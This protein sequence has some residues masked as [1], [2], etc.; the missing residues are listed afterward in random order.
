M[1]LPKGLAMAALMLLM[2]MTFFDILLRSTVNA[3]I[4]ATT[5]L[6][7]ILLMFVVFAAMPEV[8]LRGT[9]VAVDLLAP[10]LDRVGFARI[11]GLI[12]IGSAVLMVWPDQ[13][14]LT[15]AMRSKSYDDMTEFLHIPTYLPALCV[16]AFMVMTTACFAIAGLWLLLTGYSF[17]FERRE[18]KEW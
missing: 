6:S 1:R 4:E 10:V 13:K 12:L 9:H 16:F 17:G 8:T 7:R 5:E 18:A 15:L 2:V 3:P 14:I 11:E